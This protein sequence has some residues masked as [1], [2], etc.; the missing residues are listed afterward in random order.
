MMWLDDSE[1]FYNIFGGTQDNS[2]EGGPRE[3][4]LGRVFKIQIG[5]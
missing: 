1:P 3:Q 5:E 4:T 2:T